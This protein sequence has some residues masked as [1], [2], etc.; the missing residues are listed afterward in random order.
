MINEQII[1]YI[2]QQLSQNVSREGIT[3]NLKGS[4]WVDEDI[5]EAFNA[6]SLAVA[7]TPTSSSTINNST[8]QPFS[9]LSST[10]PISKGKK[11]FGI[12][13]LFLLLCLAGGGAYAYYSGMFVSLPSLT[14]QAFE[15][16]RATTSGGYDVTASVDFS[17]IKD[18][19]NLFPSPLNSKKLSVTVK[20]S[21]DSGDPDNFKSS[22]VISLDADPSS[23]AIEVRALDDVVYASMTKAPS[24]LDL[25]LPNISSYENKWISFPY[26]SKDGEVVSNPLAPFS[27]ISPGII[28]KLTSEQKEQIYELSSKTSFIKMIERFSPETIGGESSYHFAFDLDREGIRSYLESIKKYINE[29]GKNDSS[30]TAFDPTSFSKELDNVKDFKGEIWIGRSD[31]LIH[32]I[33]LNFGVLPDPAKTEQVKITVVAIMSDWNEPVSI[34]AP[35]EHMNLQELIAK[36]LG[37]AREKGKEAEIKANLSAMRAQAEL[38]YDSTSTYKGFCLSKELINARTSIENAGGTEFVC[39][40]IMEAY[41]IGTKFPQDSGYWCVDSTGVSRST[42]TLPSSTACPL[43]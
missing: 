9:P 37:E 25:F 7:P 28:N 17:E 34:I 13:G 8:E 38:F 21:Y 33:V 22:T 15:K 20:G 41:A 10:S 32:K 6:L 19:I 4:G 23:L 1:A 30:L 35:A 24:G 42:T 3:T 27:G 31:K 18:M 40:N 5:T 2:R 14:T 11:I 29:I 12:V 36:A 43:K 39:K 26:K 16:A